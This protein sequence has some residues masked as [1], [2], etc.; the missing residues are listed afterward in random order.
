MARITTI[1]GLLKKYA[2]DAI[3]A[4]GYLWRCVVDFEV[5]GPNAVYTRITSRSKASGRKAARKIALYKALSLIKKDLKKPESLSLTLKRTSTESTESPPPLHDIFPILRMAVQ[6]ADID[7]LVAHIDFPRSH[8]PLPLEDAIEP[9]RIL[10]LDYLQKLLISS[11]LQH[12]V[13]LNRPATRSLSCAVEHFVAVSKKSDPEAK[14]ECV[15][16]ELCSRLGVKATAETLQALKAIVVDWASKT[17]KV[18]QQ[19]DAA[20]QQNDMDKMNTEETTTDQTAATNP[21]GQQ[22]QDSQASTSALPSANMLDQE[23][24]SGEDVEKLRPITSPYLRLICVTDS[25]RCDAVIKFY[26]TLKAMNPRPFEQC[27]C[28]LSGDEVF[29]MAQQMEL[30]IL[31]RI[32][33]QIIQGRLTLTRA[34]IINEYHTL[35]AKKCEEYMIRSTFYRGVKK[36]HLLARKMMKQARR[37]VQPMISKSFGFFLKTVSRWG[38]RI[39]VTCPPPAVPAVSIEIDMEDAE[40]EDKANFFRPSQ[41]T[42]LSAQY[43]N[44]FPS[45]S[46]MA[47]SLSQLQA[48]FSANPQAGPVNNS[49][50]HNNS[51]PAITMPQPSQAPEPQGQAQAQATVMNTSETLTQNDLAQ[52]QQP[53]SQTPAALTISSEIRSEIIVDF[54]DTFVNANTKIPRLNQGLENELLKDLM[55]AGSAPFWNDFVPLSAEQLANMAKKFEDV[56]VQELQKKI[57]SKTV[58]QAKQD[59]EYRKLASKLG[60]SS[61]AKGIERFATEV[62]NLREG[63]KSQP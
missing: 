12:K 9:S 20:R 35:Q 52:L 37:K 3:S 47:A 30:R 63:E 39:S 6:V 40:A 41:A 32:H 4:H 15:G 48:T 34:A 16:R 18:Q 45:L 13:Q 46:S 23:M 25:D 54:Y 22:N 42:F 56:V 59:M 33:Q 5:E 50:G 24:L 31:M 17:E 53:M 8:M 61:K 38:K 21:A 60:I 1:T 11:M 26:Q 58:A 36:F 7:V 62:Q 19:I 28:R 49:Q 27:V 14:V 44:A 2:S 55:L 10:D 51:N 57:G 29:E 43:L